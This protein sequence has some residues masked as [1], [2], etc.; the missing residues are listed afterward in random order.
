MFWLFLSV[1][2]FIAISQIPIFLSIAK[3][4][5]YRPRLVE[6]L[7]ENDMPLESVLKYAANGGELGHGGNR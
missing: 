5:N 3:K 6:R 4:S 1:F 7:G 2:V